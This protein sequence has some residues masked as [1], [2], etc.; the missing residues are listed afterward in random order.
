MMMMMMVMMMTMMIVVAVM[1][2][3]E[4]ITIAAH[5]NAIPRGNAGKHLIFAPNPPPLPP[6]IQKTHGMG[7]GSSK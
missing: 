4:V 5:S 1:T 3:V 6:P 2:Q 7:G